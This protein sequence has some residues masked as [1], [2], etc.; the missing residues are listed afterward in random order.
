MKKKLII[1]FTLSLITIATV[2]L[3]GIAAEYTPGQ[4]LK[5]GFIY[6][7]PVG[8]YA[9]NY[10]HDQARL[11]TAGVFPWLETAYVENVRETDVQTYIDQLVRQG[12]QVIFADSIAYQDGVLAAAR[13]YPE[14]IFGLCNGFKN[15][16]NVATYWITLDPLFYINGLMA[17]VLTETNKVGFVLPHP[18]PEIK[19]ALIAFTRGVQEVNS[20]AV[21]DGRWTYEWYNPPAEKEATEALIG[22]GCDVIIHDM[23]SSTPVQVAGSQGI[24]TFSHCSPM[25]D[26]APD[27]VVSGHLVHY[28]VI[29]EDFLAKVYAG[30]YTSHNLEKVK[31]WWSMPQ[32][33]L[34]LGGTYGVPINPLFE[35]EFKTAKVTDPVLGEMSIYDLIFTR[36]EQMADPQM[37][38]CPFDGPLYDNQGNLR[39][40]A[41]IRL[42]KEEQEV[43]DWYP[44]GYIGP[45]P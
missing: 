44:A 24:A 1:V 25:L 42:T 6:D 43:L 10:A 38:F 34:E 21:V 19:R 18:I 39:V 28:E 20:E 11:A 40:P 4:A 26:F 14:V 12:C 16:P 45:T 33:G 35:E 41:S 5:A 17:G 15:A 32:G 27:Y 7:S 31:Y 37:A 2:Y 36:L 22:S 30:L 29:Y 23:S 9:W 13:R 8:D 3:V